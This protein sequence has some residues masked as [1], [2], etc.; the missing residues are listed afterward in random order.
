MNN[1]ILLIYCI[2]VMSSINL[3]TMDAKQWYPI[4][5]DTN[6]YYLCHHREDTNRCMQICKNIDS[7]ITG[8]CLTTLCYCI[9]T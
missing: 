6:S 8:F 1:A 3:A 9:Q 2:T 5:K 4:N 7:E